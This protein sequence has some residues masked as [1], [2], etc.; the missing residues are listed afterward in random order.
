MVCSTGSNGVAMASAAPS[1]PATIAMIRAVRWLLPVTG[2]DHG[3][4]W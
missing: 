2:L 3:A 1:S 4:R